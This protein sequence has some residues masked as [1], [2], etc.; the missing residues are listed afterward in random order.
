MKAGGLSKKKSSDLLAMLAILVEYLYRI[1][2]TLF[3]W[4]NAA[5]YSLQM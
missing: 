2:K 3:A 5:K 4:V 1:K